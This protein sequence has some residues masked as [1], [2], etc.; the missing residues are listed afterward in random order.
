MNRLVDSYNSYRS[1]AQ[2]QR[3]ESQGATGGSEERGWRCGDNVDVSRPSCRLKELCN[4]WAG[5]E[6]PTTG[7]ARARGGE[8][9]SDAGLSSSRGD[10][11]GPSTDEHDASR[12][13]RSRTGVH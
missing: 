1:P 5:A 13:A 3:P 8:T 7:K 4:R 10:G 9:L 12:P 2:Q 6:K 11:V